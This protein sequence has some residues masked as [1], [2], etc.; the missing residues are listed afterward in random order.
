MSSCLSR[1]DKI[2]LA[3]I[4]FKIVSVQFGYSMSVKMFSKR[5]QL[6]TISIVTR[7]LIYCPSSA[8]TQ[9]LVRVEKYFIVVP[10]EP[11]LKS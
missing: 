8:C 6:L 10:V 1:Y 7:T 2:L 4:D 5:D 3:C 9:F 11:T